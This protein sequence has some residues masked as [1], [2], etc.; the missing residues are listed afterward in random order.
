M[1]LHIGLDPGEEVGDLGEDAGLSVTGP[2]SPGHDAG[3]VELAGFRLGGA[4]EGA[5]RVA[6]AA[7]AVGG[8]ESHHAGI[9][10]IRPLGLQIRVRP[11]F[12]LELLKDVGPGFRRG[13]DE[14]P[15][16]K[17]ASFGSVIVVTGVGHAGGSGI[18]PG[19]VNVGGQL[20]QGDV[21]LDRMGLVEHR[22]DDDVRN[23]EVF[24]GAIVIIFMPFSDAN[25]ELGGVLGAAE[26][27]S[28]A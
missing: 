5:A 22:V 24:F 10:H 13:A 23:D 12:A 25:P 27:V 16:G 15:A 2:G 9:D 14:T 7:G 1:K 21:V 19:E 17:P 3:D 28:G 18:R 4:D 11:D 8:A 26:A 6:H 20:D